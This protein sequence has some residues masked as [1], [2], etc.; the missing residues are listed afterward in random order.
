M[1]DT[2]PLLIKTDF[3]AMR[4]RP[5]ETLQ[6]NL[7]YRCNQSCVHCHVAA[8]PQRTEAM[9]RETMVSPYG[10]SRAVVAAAP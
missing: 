8:S 6:A 9:C 3:P 1:R 10:R 5:L 2:S 7:G 4:R